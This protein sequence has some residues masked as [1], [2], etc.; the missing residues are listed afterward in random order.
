MTQ[1]SG[2]PSWKEAARDYTPPRSCRWDV[3]ISH[4]GNSADT[5]FASALYRM[6]EGTSWGLEVFLAHES[7]QY[8]Q[9]GWG[10]IEA[11]INT[12]A[13]AVLLFST[14]YFERECPR[15]ELKMFI[16]RHALHRVLLLP[17][18]LRLRVEE[19]NR[20]AADVLQQGAPFMQAPCASNSATH[21]IWTI[22]LVVE[23]ASLCSDCT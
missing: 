2:E 9:N 17:V 13:I 23:V 20:R 6:L 22:G 12:S 15:K 8:A 1:Q 11:A 3:F 4:A 21:C 7:L 16:E 5:P 10:G 18:F 19:C 14:E